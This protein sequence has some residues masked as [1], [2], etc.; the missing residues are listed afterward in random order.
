MLIKWWLECSF[1]ALFYLRE[2]QNSFDTTM[3]AVA[4]I[5]LHNDESACDR[6]IK[7]NLAN[8]IIAISNSRSCAIIQLLE[9]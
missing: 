1:F 6:K 9:F 8:N 5:G 4:K 3:A 2:L 7:Q